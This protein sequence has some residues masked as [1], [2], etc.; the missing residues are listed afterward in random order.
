VMGHRSGK[1]S[2]THWIV[3]FKSGDINA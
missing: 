1:L 2:K 3:Y